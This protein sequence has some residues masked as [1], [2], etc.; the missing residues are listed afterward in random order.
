MWIHINLRVRIYLI[1]AI[2]VVVTSLGGLIL[3]RYTYQMED[4]LSSIIDKDLAAFQS[5]EDLEHSLVNQKGFVSYYF[6][7]G[8]PKWLRQLG[9]FRQIFKQ[10]ISEALVHANTPGQKEA[11]EQINKE[12]KLY[13]EGKDR[14]I[15]FYTSGKKEVGLKLHEKVRAHYF[16]ILDLCAGYKDFHK[17]RILQA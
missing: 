16:K 3:V 8:D 6:M 14:V 13:I 9:E 1:L 5:A 7:D 2:L 17:K 4:V 12:Y 10:K 11:A 15:A